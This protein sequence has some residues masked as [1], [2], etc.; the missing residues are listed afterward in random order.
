MLRYKTICTSLLAIV[1]AVVSMTMSPCSAIAKT[2]HVDIERLIQD[3][4]SASGAKRLRAVE[5]LGNSGDLRALQPL[6]GLLN[7]VDPSIRERALKALQTLS[8]NL[9][10][11]YTHIAQ[12]VDQILLQFNIYLAPELP[13]ERT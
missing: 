13:V 3:A 2:D 8:Q 12:W 6:L 5:A 7:D 9:R 1:I 10:Q 4:T 11:I